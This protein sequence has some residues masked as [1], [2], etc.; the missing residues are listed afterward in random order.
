MPRHLSSNNLRRK[1]LP[2][3]SIMLY[4]PIEMKNRTQDRG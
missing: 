3:D 4:A 2:G 1:R